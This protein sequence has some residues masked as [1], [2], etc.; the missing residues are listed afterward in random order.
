[1]FYVYNRGDFM[2]R[3]EAQK[4]ADK[5][6]NQKR[7]RDGS[8]KNLSVKIS[9]TDYNILDTYCKTVTVSKAVFIVRACKY[10]IKHNIDLSKED[11]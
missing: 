9:P 2:P 7:M 3:S 4:R 11:I 8:I 1:M 5:K 10:C 6:Y